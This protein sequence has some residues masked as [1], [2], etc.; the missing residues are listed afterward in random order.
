LTRGFRQHPSLDPVEL[1]AAQ[2][3]ALRAK[4]LFDLLDLVS[5][6]IVHRSLIRTRRAI[7]D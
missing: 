7:P 2:L 4:T 6:Q 1:D 5:V 3:P